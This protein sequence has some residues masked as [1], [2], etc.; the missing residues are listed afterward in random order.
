MEEHFK[1][2]MLEDMQYLFYAKGSTPLGCGIW[3][4]DHIE[5]IPKT[6][7]CAEIKIE[8]VEYAIFL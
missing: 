5:L 7:G 6:C 3:K 1:E 4:G 2:Y 8:D